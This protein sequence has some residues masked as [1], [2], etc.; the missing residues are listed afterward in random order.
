MLPDRYNLENLATALRNPA[1]LKTELGRLISYRAF[2]MVHGDGIDVVEQDWDTLVL[3]DACR[4]DRFSER[5]D[6]TG[7]EGDLDSVISRGPES[8][9]F[10]RNNFVGRELHDTIYVSANPHVS[11]LSDDVFFRIEPLL[12]SWDPDTETI[13][14]REVVEAAVRM[15]DEHPNKRLIVHFMQPHI[16]YIGSTAERIRSSVSISGLGLGDHPGNEQRNGDGYRWWDAIEANEIS[17]EETHEAY[18]ESL[19]IVLDHVTELLDDVDGKSVITAD[20]GEL[21]GERLVPFGARRY[22]HPPLYTTELCEVPWFETEF[23]E[24]REIVSEDPL[25]DD[26]MDPEEVTERLRALGYA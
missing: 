11:K 21:L 22:G 1:V 18:V 8:W 6:R 15:H 25:T 7:I 5:I 10:I 3:L 24:R 19:D 4:Y 17:R 20:H 23:G 2:T 14:P 9:T 16:P 13:P 12:D 26:R